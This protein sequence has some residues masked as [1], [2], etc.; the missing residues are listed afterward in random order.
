[1]SVSR[2]IGNKRGRR[3]ENVKQNGKGSK[4]AREQR[5]ESDRIGRGKGKQRGN[6][7][8][9]TGIVQIGLWLARRERGR[10]QGSGNDK[11]EIRHRSHRGL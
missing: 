2:R 3:R 8:G 1:M 6:S 7:K 5:R 11:I 9:R 4:N 10:N